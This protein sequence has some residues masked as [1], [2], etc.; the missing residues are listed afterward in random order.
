MEQTCQDQSAHGAAGTRK[1][2]ISHDFHF[3]E[4]KHAR[5]TP[6]KMSV[7]ESIERVALPSSAY[8]IP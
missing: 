2:G 4:C 6:M 3:D 7:H 5:G 1:R 8:P